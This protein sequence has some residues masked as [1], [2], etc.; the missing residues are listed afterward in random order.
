MKNCATTFRRVINQSTAGED[1]RS[2][3]LLGQD[4]SNGLK[5]NQ[6]L[7]RNFGGFLNN[8]A[9]SNNLIEV[10]LALFGGCLF[11]GCI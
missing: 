5:F 4:I 3:L 7:V 9:S 10:R 2:L 11:F 8:L 1:K 6:F